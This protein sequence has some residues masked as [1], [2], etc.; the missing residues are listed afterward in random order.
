LVAVFLA[1]SA[2]HA[3]SQSYT[4]VDLY[5]LT[6]PIG[7]TAIGYDYQPVAAP[8]VIAGTCYV[9]GW[10]HAY[11]WHG[12]STPTEL[13]PAGV[14]FANVSGTDGIRQVGYGV[15]SATS[16]QIH[17]LVWNGNN[18][19]VD[20]HPAGMTQSRA[21]SVSGNQ[22][23]GAGRTVASGTLDHALVWNGDSAIDLHPAGLQRS[24]AFGADGSHQVGSGSATPIGLDEHALLWSGANSAIDLHPAGYSRSFAIGVAD[25]EQVG[26][27]VPES[28]GKETALLWHGTNQAISLNPAG[29]DLCH[30]YFTNGS[31]QVGYGAGTATGNVA[32]ALLWNGT[33]VP[34]DLG[35][36]IPP[37]LLSSLAYS[38][39][40]AGNVYG[41]AYDYG[42]NDWHA[43][44]WM[45]PEPASLAWSALGVLCLR[46]QFRRA[47]VHPL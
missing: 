29:Y 11:F 1:I 22:I 21:F 35:A 15:G 9:D 27:G 19:P 26:W 12:S 5:T 36:L 43:V 10:A 37:T 28:G 47:A 18:V 44:A 34:A 4:F 33:N 42:K 45:V 31:Q 39:D 40:P 46:R 32:H 38:M 3:R 13:T 7:S 17:A 16:N 30:A 14:L 6:R 25:N 20:V 8:G 2:D 24:W 23:A 41:V